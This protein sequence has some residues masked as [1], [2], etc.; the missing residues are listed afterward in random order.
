MADLTIKFATEE[1]A[2]QFATWL[3]EAGEQDYW[4]WAEIATK[5]PIRASDPRHFVGDFDY[6]NG[7]DFCHDMTI[8]T[9]GILI[10]ED[11]EPEFAHCPFCEGYGR[12]GTKY[13][14]RICKKCG[15]SGLKSEE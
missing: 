13:P 12:L 1:Q 3:C 7:S 2:L 5:H 8:R 15:G 14:P 11:K 9:Y 6:H 10:D 4:M